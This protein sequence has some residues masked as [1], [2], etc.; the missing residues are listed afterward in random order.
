MVGVREEGVRGEGDACSSS[1][2]V[3]P[4]Y[5]SPCFLGDMPGLHSDCVSFWYQY[6][7]PLQCPSFSELKREVAFGVRSVSSCPCLP[8]HVCLLNVSVHVHACSYWT[9]PSALVIGSQGTWKTE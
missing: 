6:E 4:L 8:L 5:N 1:V 2:A 3:G 9:V 7:T